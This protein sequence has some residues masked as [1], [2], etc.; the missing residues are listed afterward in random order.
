[1][2][3]AWHVKDTFVQEILAANL[4]ENDHLVDPYVNGRTLFQQ[5]IRKENGSIGSGEGP[6]VDSC[7]HNY[8]H[9]NC[10]KFLTILTM[11][12]TP[13]LQTFP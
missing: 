13:K 10:I 6:V 4:G 3:W 11:V 8:E 7:E 5:T 12:K 1:M 2:R 9:S